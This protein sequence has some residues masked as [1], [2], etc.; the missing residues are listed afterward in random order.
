M[1]REELE[2]VAKAVSVG[3]NNIVE[4]LDNNLPEPLHPS[5]VLAEIETDEELQKVAENWILEAEEE[6]ERRRRLFQDEIDR[7][8]EVRVNARR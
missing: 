1:N 7:R 4:R 2:S 8:T 6:T 5:Q 3:V